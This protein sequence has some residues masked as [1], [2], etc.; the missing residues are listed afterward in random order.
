VAYEHSHTKGGQ[1]DKYTHTYTE[2]ERERE[3]R[4]YSHS[5]LE[6]NEMITVN[7]IQKDT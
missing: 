6:V 4:T 3:M 5:E 7:E 2:R 1:T